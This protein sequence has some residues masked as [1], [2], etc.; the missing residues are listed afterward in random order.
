MLTLLGALRDFLIA[1][2]LAWVGVT[3]EPR[4]DG[5]RCATAGERCETPT[6]N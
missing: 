5:E 4:V 3:V 1:L 6:R 2:A